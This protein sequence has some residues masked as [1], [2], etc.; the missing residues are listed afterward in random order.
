MKIIKTKLVRYLNASAITIWPII[1]AEPDYEMYP[2]IIQHETVHY[3]QGRRW[4]IYGL[5]VGLLVWWFL[6]MLV[7]PVGWNPFRKKWEKEAYRA[8]GFSDEQID[9]F[10]RKP[11]YYLWWM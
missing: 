2:G 9:E 6:Y 1:F 10:M 5:G 7:L 4:A 11:P 8:E 3:Y